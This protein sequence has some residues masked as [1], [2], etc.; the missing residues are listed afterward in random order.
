MWD[1]A[2][3]EERGMPHYGLIALVPPHELVALFV[4]FLVVCVP[5]VVLS[6]P[7]LAIWTHHRR[8]M[9][10]IRL[11]RETNISDAVRAEFAA[12]RAEIQSLRDTSMQYDLSFDTNLQQLE[13][14]VAQMERQQGASRQAAPEEAYN[15]HY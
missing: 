1:W 3:E 6:I 2:G 9:E 4:F 15:R 12:V 14:R 7:L 11:R 5:M 13:R 8:K 10:E